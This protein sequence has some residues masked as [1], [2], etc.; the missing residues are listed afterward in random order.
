MNCQQTVTT[1]LESAK[2]A[3]FSEKKTREGVALSKLHILIYF[4]LLK[5]SSLCWL[6]GYPIS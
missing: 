2:I 4:R 6:S 1:R 3:D 5:Y